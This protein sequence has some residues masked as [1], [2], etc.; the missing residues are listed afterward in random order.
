MPGNIPAP[1]D[2][3]AERELWERRYGGETWTAIG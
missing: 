2:G 1:L 3:E